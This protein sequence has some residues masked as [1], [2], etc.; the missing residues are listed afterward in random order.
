MTMQRPPDVVEIIGHFKL[1]GS[2]GGEKQGEGDI[3]PYA[4]ARREDSQ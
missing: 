4:A 2:I 1:S 3:R